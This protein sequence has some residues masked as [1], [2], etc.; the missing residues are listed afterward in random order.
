MSDIASVKRQA[1]IGRQIRLPLRKVVE[2]SFRSLKI[3]LGRAALTT[4][5]VVLA[6]AFLMSVW[7]NSAILQSLQQ[8]SADLKSITRMKLQK[9]TGA[10]GEVEKNRNRN[11]ML[12]S[13]S[14]IVCV[15][16]VV[17]AMLMSVT[18]RFREIGT[19][20]CLGALDGFIIKLFLIESAFQGAI[21]AVVGSIIGLLLASVSK[22]VSFGPEVLRYFPVM[23]VI[24]F[25]ML[26]VVIGVALTIAGAVYPA[27]VAARMKP[28]DA[29]RV[30]Q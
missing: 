8:N 26:T 9:K 19:M 13:L 4:G 27:Y 5:G 11:V 23:S 2:I 14:L 10:A 24:N 18:E 17:N 21:G 7:T 12:V 1:G 25:A 28:V 3:R 16:G 20:K 22:L 15:T 6:L 30:E 29:M